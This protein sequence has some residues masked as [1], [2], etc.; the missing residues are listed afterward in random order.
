MQ[1]SNWVEAEDLAVRDEI[2]FWQKKWDNYKK[3][4]TG[5]EV[6]ITGRIVELNSQKV[7]LSIWGEW[8]V[9]KITTVEKGRPERLELGRI[10][11]DPTVWLRKPKKR[12][13][14]YDPE[15]DPLMQAIAK[16]DWRDERERR[17][18]L[19]LNQ[20]S[21]PESDTKTTELEECINKDI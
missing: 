21:V 9:K 13:Y 2:R 8:I 19:R 11:R 4:W 20:S 14:I 18:E 17:R 16:D 6:Q 12:R 15:R 5:E 10:D 7:T 1:E 3:E